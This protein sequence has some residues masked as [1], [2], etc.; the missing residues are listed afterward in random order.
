MATPAGLGRHNEN[1]HV[2]CPTDPS[3]IIEA[4][5]EFAGPTNRDDDPENENPGALGGATG[6][7]E[8]PLAGRSQ[9][10]FKHISDAIPAR[11]AGVAGAIYSE[12]ALARAGEG[13]PDALAFVLAARLNCA[14]LRNL[15]RAVIAAGVARREVLE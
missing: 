3:T 13:R 2:A 6:A 14:E 9:C 15:A 4:K 5:G 8:M 10:S 11:Y 12:L 1:R 7:N